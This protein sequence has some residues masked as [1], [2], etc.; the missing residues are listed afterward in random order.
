MLLSDAFP[1]FVVEADEMHTDIF[2]EKY[3]IE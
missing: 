1:Y 2:F 3:S